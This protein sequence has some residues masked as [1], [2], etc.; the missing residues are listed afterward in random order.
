MPSLAWVNYTS[1]SG[2]VQHLIP[3]DWA[4]GDS[5]RRGWSSIR[6]PSVIR[7][8]SSVIRRDVGRRILE[9][10]CQGPKV[11]VVIVRTKKSPPKWAGFNRRGHRAHAAAGRTTPARGLGLA[12]G[13]A[14]TISYFATSLISVPTCTLRHWSEPS[15]TFASKR[16]SIWTV[17]NLPSNLNVRLAHQSAA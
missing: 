5:S 11:I 17:P 10:V 2:Y 8:P 4:T 14:Q 13:Q 15:L 3:W 12:L 1:N 6:H 16:T 9:P 7:H